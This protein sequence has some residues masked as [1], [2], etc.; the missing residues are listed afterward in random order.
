V[1]CSPNEAPPNPQNEKEISINC[2][3]TILS[4]NAKPGAL[5]ALRCPIGCGGVESIPV[6]AGKDNQ[7]AEKSSICRSAAYMGLSKDEE[8][9]TVLI[10]VI[11]AKE[12]FEGSSGE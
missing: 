11:A 6:Y 7:F 5:M 9:S 3:D 4:R 8:E 10:K 12:K 2:K 1:V